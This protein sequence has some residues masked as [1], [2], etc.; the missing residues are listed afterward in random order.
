MKKK[1]QEAVKIVMRLYYYKK[2][3]DKTIWC[4]FMNVSEVMKTN[5]LVIRNKKDV[6]DMF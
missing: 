6:K 1:I 5:M 2:D 3:D 4:F